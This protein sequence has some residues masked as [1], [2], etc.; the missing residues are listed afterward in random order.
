MTEGQ[1]GG[2]PH[3]PVESIAAEPGAPPRFERRRADWEEDL[4]AALIGL[5]GAESAVSL[6][7]DVV[8]A[9]RRSAALRS[10][11]LRRLDEGREG[12]PRWYQSVHMV[13]YQAYAD[14]FGGDLHGVR[15]R[16]PY[17]AELGVTLLHLMS[18]VRPRD[19]ANDGGYAVQDYRSPDPAL[20][21]GEALVA[22]ASGLREAGI[23][24]CLDFVMNHTADTHEWAR[25]ARGGDR[26]RRSFYLTYPDRSTPDAFEAT[27]PEVFPDAAPGNFSFDAELGAWVWT[28][29]HSFQ[30][31][32]N[33]ANPAVL[34]AMIDNLLYLANLGVEVVRLDAVAFT[35]KRLGTNCQN[36]PEAHLVAQAMRAALGMAAPATVLLAEAIVG[37]DELVPYLGGHE[38]ERR[39]CE[40]AY[41]NQLMVLGWSMLAERQ[42][43]LATSA[44][45]RFATAPERTQ[46]LTY[47]RCHDDIG[48]AVT[49][50]DAGAVGLGG[51]AHRAFLADFYSGRFPGSFA[52]GEPF[53]INPRSGDERTSGG[54]AS[55]CGLSRARRASERGE[56]DL[57]IGR[58]LLLH[59]LSFGWGGIPLLYMGDELGIDDD[60]DYRG[61][62]ARSADS[63]WRHR[64][65]MDWA[66]AGRR[67]DRS[68]VEGRLWAGVGRLITVRRQCPMLGGGG[69]TTAIGPWHPQVFAWVRR[70]PRWGALVG[71]ANVSERPVA[72]RLPPG[73]PAVAGLDTPVDRL[74]G[75][76]VEAAAV[77]P[78]A[79][80]Q[81]RWLTGPPGLAVRPTPRR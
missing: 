55:L 46:W 28:T 34:L 80:Y 35:G 24:L 10:D 13:G 67:H 14:R 56:I 16:I 50:E 60:L 45:R 77:L 40:L 20:G 69:R 11:A 3:G 31:D 7:E 68:S 42:T 36:Q 25:Q 63:R 6:V 27:L 52:E 22:L 12:D 5:Y 17:L 78:M 4:R 76:P 72:L 8:V 43:G 49:D 62:A 32:L 21:D 66:A 64:P 15:A 37:P 9:A 73:D 58:V 54:T 38:L 44:L 81:L 71:L 74:S 48:W 30:W 29:F 2:T 33:Y 39:E 59:G 70:H 1:N 51:A 47:V 79:P 57:A 61:D 23:S 26:T 65:P 53:S 18:V 75:E 19:G 41:H